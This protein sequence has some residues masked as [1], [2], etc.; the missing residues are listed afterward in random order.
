MTDFPLALSQSVRPFVSERITATLTLEEGLLP[1]ASIRQGI[2]GPQKGEPRVV[3][4]ET[5]GPRLYQK[6]SH[7]GTS[8]VSATWMMPLLVEN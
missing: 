4:S 6:L 7:F 2:A 8:M 5:R 3:G 1:L